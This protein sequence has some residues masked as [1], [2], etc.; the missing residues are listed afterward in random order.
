MLQR[1]SEHR[2]IIVFY[3]KRFCDAYGIIS[4]QSNTIKEMILVLSGLHLQS[5]I[6]FRHSS[7]S[8]YRETKQYT[9]APGV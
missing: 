5:P 8:H 4:S 6:A 1:I 2:T 3:R 7:V 9:L